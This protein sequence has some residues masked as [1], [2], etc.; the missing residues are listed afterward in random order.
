LYVKSNTPNKRPITAKI[1]KLP[2]CN[3]YLL[4]LA[5]RGGAKG[6]VE[7]VRGSP[8]NKGSKVTGETLRCFRG[9]KL[10]KSPRKM[11][12]W[13]KCFEYNVSL[14]GAQYEEEGGH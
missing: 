12:D 13:G 2:N 11:R 8:K 14:P 5:M 3:R 9:G 1:V 4:D 7:T 6:V 10:R